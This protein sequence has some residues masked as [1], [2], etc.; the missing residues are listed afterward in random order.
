[1]KV[2]LYK[3]FEHWYHGGTIWLYSDTHFQ[4][5]EEMEKFFNWPTKE[6]RLN[7]INKCVTKNDSFILLGDVGNEL[8]LISKIRAD[9]KVLITGNHDKGVSNYI[10]KEKFI[11][12]MYPDE[13]KA[14]CIK[15]TDWYVK[16]S[17]KLKVGVYCKDGY[18]DEV[19]DGP[20]FIAD[21]IL[22]SHERIK[23]PFCVN[24]HG[25]E[26]CGTRIGIAVY[27]NH[28]SYSYNIAA[29][30]I[31]FIPVR[32]DKLVQEHPLKDIPSIHRLTIDRAT[33][34]KGE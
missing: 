14:E 27:E 1:M 33:E 25:H 22:L 6:E 23:L 24:I 4:T 31:D 5:D 19:Y 2:K 32:L 7:L 8:D 26:H 29:D 13:A 12:W 18:F 9:Y 11:D 15:H 16:D 10:K 3:P 20:L 21:K 28:V 34:L 17:H 30:V